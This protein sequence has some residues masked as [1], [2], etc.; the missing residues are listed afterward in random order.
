MIPY[1]PLGEIKSKED[2]LMHHEILVEDLEGRNPLFGKS[3]DY[4]WNDRR[5]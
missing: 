3:A 2:T 1:F 4:R 5:I